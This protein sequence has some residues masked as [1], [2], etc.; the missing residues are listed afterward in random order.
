ML[1]LHIWLRFICSYTRAKAYSLIV[2]KNL[3][4][5]SYHLS[6]SLSASLL[7][8]WLAKFSA[9]V[10]FDVTSPRLNQREK[11]KKKVQIRLCCEK[12]GI[13]FSSL[14]CT[15]LLVQRT[16]YPLRFNQSDGTL[17]PNATQL[18]AFSHP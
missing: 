13:V 17:R 11:T 9:A 3:C 6:L 14:P 7:L 18:F 8:S 1:F 15:L 5:L 10:F 16:H 4:T 12:F 2:E